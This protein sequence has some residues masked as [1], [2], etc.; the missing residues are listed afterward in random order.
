MS[1]ASN[2]KP[3]RRWSAARSGDRLGS[4]LQRELVGDARTL[5]HLHAEHA[6]RTVTLPVVHFGTRWIPLVELEQR[7]MRADRRRNARILRA[8]GYVVL[9]TPPWWRQS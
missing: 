8:L 1:A 2:S 3:V 7:E 9:P 5:E 4:R 6:R